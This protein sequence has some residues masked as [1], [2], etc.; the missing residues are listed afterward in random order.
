MNKRDFYLAA[1][2]AGCY[3]KTKWNIAAFSL[4]SEGPEDWKSD[5]YPYRLVSLPNGYHFVN[6]DDYTSLVKI[7]DGVVGKPLLRALE[8]ID[9]Q[10][11]DVENV[12]VPITTTY[13]NVMANYICL[14][15]AFGNK[16]PFQVGRMN[17]KKI[18]A[19][20]ETRLTENPADFVEDGG[21][22]PHDRSRFDNIAQAQGMAF[23][24]SG[25]PDDE[26]IYI[27]EYL[28]FCNGTFSTVAY[29]QIFTPA[30]TRKTMTGPPGIKE[31]RD[32]LVKENEGRLH[33][34]AV[35]ASIVEQLQKVDAE[36]LKG[37]RGLG[38][39]ISAKSKQIV[40][41]KMF[42]SYGAE[43]G[44]EEK[45]DVDFI[46]RSLTEG[47]DVSKFASMNNA[48]RAGSY[49]R[50]KQTELG[51]EAVKD[52]LRATSNMTISGKDCGSTYGIDDY[53]PQG[54]EKRLIGFSVIEN[55]ATVKVTKENVGEYM[56]KKLMRRTPMTCKMEKTDFCAVCLGDRLANT[57]T[58]LS[59]AI[60]DYG[61]AFLAIFMSA[62][63]SK[64]IR[65]KKLDIHAQLR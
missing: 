26:P 1:C 18:E 43:T 62:A 21:Y 36:Y 5:P 48:L 24:S 65:A 15:Y 33:D 51:G 30:A 52:I 61:S 25:S 32:K 29:T 59:M 58:G 55:G 11:G 45:V 50:G 40:R 35:V 7:E 63:H 10:V 64:G 17:I 31:L 57:P 37:D 28:R 19:I 12:R 8:A 56:G 38:F 44:I 9:L 39:L 3:K 46:Q 27:D 13:G 4:V 20:I 42:L 22:N 60:A 54:E 41:S 14:V 6:P 23:N 47:W 34:R 16:I 53:Y 2:K 49:N